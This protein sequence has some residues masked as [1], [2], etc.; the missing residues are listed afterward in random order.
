M[1]DVPAA[2]AKMTVETFV[3]RYEEKGPF[4]ILDGQI[5]PMSPPGFTHSLIAKRLFMMFLEHEGA[6]IGE[7]FMETPFI[8][9]DFEGAN[10]VKGSRVPDVMFVSAK[11]MAA[12][13][14][15]KPEPGN[16]P[17]SVVPELAVEIVSP[18][19]RYTAILHKVS[20]YLD[21]GVRQVWLIDPGE[22]TV[23][24][25]VAGSKQQAI[26]RPGDTLNGGETVPGLEI[27][28]ATLFER[29]TAQDNQ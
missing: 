13:R 29:D 10:W 12:F 17:L 6:E 14:A 7:A 27:P 28:V 2:T 23:T 9:S 18:N 16:D 15:A 24:V 22:R 11:K 5:V 20:L 4:E 3:R 21:D 8:K 1:T 19:D 25:H 26:L